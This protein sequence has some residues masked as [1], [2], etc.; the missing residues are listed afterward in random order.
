MI[1]L[2]ALKSFTPAIAEREKNLTLIGTNLDL[3]MGVLFTGLTEPVTAFVSKA[4]G[5]LV[6]KIPKAA[7]KGKIS[8]IAYSGV[9]V[10]SADTLKFVGEK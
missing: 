8:L 6:V 10:E 4:P 3:T 7:A 5:Q 9:P 2:P 1:T